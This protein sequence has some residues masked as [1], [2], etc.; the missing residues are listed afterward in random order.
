VIAFSPHVGAA[1]LLLRAIGQIHPPVMVFMERQSPRAVHDLVLATRAAP[2]LRFVDADMGGARDALEHLRR[3]DV[4]LLLADRDVLGNGRPVAFFG[5]RAKL[6]TGPVELAL[7]TQLP[8]LPVTV[9]RTGA[10]RVRIVVD[11]PIVLSRS[12]NRE[13]DVAAG[14]LRLAGALEVSIQRAPDQWFALSP[15][16]SGLAH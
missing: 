5:E 9:L 2:G 12:G 10:D 16:W 14:M 7:R 13:A 6:P 3:G 4:L 15:V 8:L 11:A 1:E